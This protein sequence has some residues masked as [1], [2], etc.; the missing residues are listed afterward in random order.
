MEQPKTADQL[1]RNDRTASVREGLARVQKGLT[2]TRSDL[3]VQPPQH[4]DEGC[5]S[6]LCRPVLLCYRSSRSMT[7]PKRLSPSSRADEAMLS[8][9]KE[10]GFAAEVA[11][12]VAQT[13]LDHKEK[14]HP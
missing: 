11:A 3:N 7:S 2:D 14:A 6:P 13:S 1:L 9:L 12:Y 10:H 8:L 5:R 4:L